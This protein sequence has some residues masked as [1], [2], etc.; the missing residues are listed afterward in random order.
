MGPEPAVEA[1]ERVVAAVPAIPPVQVV[2]KVL[3]GL[4][5]PS[6]AWIHRIGIVYSFVGAA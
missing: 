4:H 5:R 6:I 3:A 2:Q 1:V